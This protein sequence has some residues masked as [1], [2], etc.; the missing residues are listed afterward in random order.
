MV[1]VSAGIFLKSYPRAPIHL[2]LNCLVSNCYR[3]KEE[4]DLISQLRILKDWSCYAMTT[5]R[6]G[7]TNGAAQLL[8]QQDRA[9]LVV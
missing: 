5:P 4:K 2:D 9:K 8:D 1:W 7:R 6:I 3:E